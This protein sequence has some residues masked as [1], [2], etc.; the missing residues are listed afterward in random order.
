MLVLKDLL[1]E[2][3]SLIAEM[4]SVLYCGFPKYSE[5]AAAFPSI[6]NGEMLQHVRGIKAVDFAA[7][8][9]GQRIHDVVVRADGYKYQS[10]WYVGDATAKYC[11]AKITGCAAEDVSCHDR[12]A[13]E[14]LVRGPFN[15]KLARKEE[16]LVAGVPANMKHGILNLPHAY[17]PRFDAAVHLRCNFRN[18]E[19]LVGERSIGCD[20]CL[21]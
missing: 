20:S 6:L 3:G 5:Y 10:G 7:H 1:L 2:D 9:A 17:A 12:Y 18:F 14:R 21:N 8:F 15:A 11:I 19:N 16:H 4:C 13:L